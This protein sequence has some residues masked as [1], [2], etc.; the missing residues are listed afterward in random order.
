MNK[1]PS[2]SHTSQVFLKISKCLYNSTMHSDEVFL[3]LLLNAKE[4]VHAF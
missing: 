4:K 3:F 1:Q 2:A